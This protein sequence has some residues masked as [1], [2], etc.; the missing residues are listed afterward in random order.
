MVSELD[1]VL[2]V[3]VESVVRYDGKDHVAVKKSDGGI[4]WREVALGQSNDRLV[5]VKQGIKSDEIVVI[6]PQTLLSDDQKRVTKN[7]PI[8]PAAKP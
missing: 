3:P 8:P 7:R 5:E 6:K 2:S 1:N 4:E